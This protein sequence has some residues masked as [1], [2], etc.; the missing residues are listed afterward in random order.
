MYLKP[1]P[2]RG[3]LVIPAT[4]GQ[5]T[6]AQASTVFTG[7]IDQHFKTYGCD[8]RSEGTLEQPV[9]VH[10][11]VENGTFKQIFGSFAVKPFTQAQVIAFVRRYRTWLAP[12]GSVTFFLFNVGEELFVATMGFGSSGLLLSVDVYQSSYKDLWFAEDRHRV[13]VSQQTPE[14]SVI[15]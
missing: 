10:K 5:E 1:I 8:V 13:V 11:L 14:T 2:S 4:D 3:K 7:Y 15:L 12:G 9:E 6:I